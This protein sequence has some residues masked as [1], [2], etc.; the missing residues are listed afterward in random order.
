MKK[1][2][3][4]NSLHLVLPNIGSRII[5]ALNNFFGVMMI[6]RLGHKQ[7]AAATLILVSFNLVFVSFLYML[8]SI[9]VVAGR[10]YGAGKYKDVGEIVQQ[11]WLLALLIS[12]PM[13]FIIWNFAYILHLAGQQPELCQIAQ[14]YFHATVWSLP[15]SM[16]SIVN[17]QFLMT[18]HKQ[19]ASFWFAFLGLIILVIFSYLL[20]YGRDG[21]PRCGV[22]GLG[23][24]YII[25]GVVLLFTGWLYMV[26]SSYFR[27]F[28]LFRWR[29][30]ETFHYLKTLYQIGWPISV[31]VFTELLSVF[32]IAMIVGWI[33]VNALAANEIVSQYLYL[34]IIPVGAISQS[35]SILISRSHGANNLFDIRHYANINAVLSLVMPAI[36][37]IIV[38][39]EPNL[40]ISVFLKLKTAVSFE[41]AR[42]ATIVL[43]IC[44]TTQFFDAIRNT[45]TGALRGLHDTKVPMLISIFSVWCIGIPM[46]YFLGIIM[47]YG[48]IGTSLGAGCGLVVGTFL[49]IFRWRTK[50]VTL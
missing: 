24:A 39:V 46:A 36:A 33:G 6:A 11:G 5:L 45:F 43:I 7:L 8:F 30:K 25:R 18:V 48:L 12:L 13:M 37:L 17:R 16:L 47:D 9:N 49:I 10:V 29:F 15:F 1:H 2:Y 38:L 41:I 32:I 26:R 3:I 31:H 44:I 21:F 27:A 4:K 20:I 28:E 40:L 50:L 19:V 22:A 14:S 35:N 34:L 42:L 23:Y